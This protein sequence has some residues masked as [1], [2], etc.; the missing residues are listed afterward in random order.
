MET[1]GCWLQTVGESTI[2]SGTLELFNDGQFRTVPSINRNDQY[3]VLFGGFFN[4]PTDGQYE[5]GNGDI[6]DPIASG[7]ISIKT[8]SSRL[9]ATWVLNPCFQL[10]NGYRSKSQGALPSGNSLHGIYQWCSVSAFSPVARR[11]ALRHLS[12]RTG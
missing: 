8:V 6:D 5:F 4:A 10:G 12:C 11:V 7:W 1:K 2:Y 9:L 3:Q